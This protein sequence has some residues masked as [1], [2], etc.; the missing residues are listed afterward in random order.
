[1]QKIKDRKTDYNI[2]YAHIY[3]DEEFGPSHREAIQIL[4]NIVRKLKQE[5]KS[6][7]LTV[8]IDDYN[9]KRQILDVKE[10]I[11]NLERLGAKPDF[12]GFESKLVPY[13]NLLLEKMSPRLY[14]EYTKYIKKNKK[15]PCSLLIAIWYLKRLGFIETRSEE[16]KCLSKDY[17]KNFVAKKIITILP[18]RYQKVEKKGLKIIASTEFK[19]CLSNIEN[20]FF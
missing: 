14:K 17:K 1:M 15:I 6:Y 5:K 12:I 13:S 2:E 8:L 18:K 20:I 3:V 7:A 19:N 11:A 16:L 9:P 10:F 4:H